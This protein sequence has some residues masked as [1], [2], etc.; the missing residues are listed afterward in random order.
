MEIN[1]LIDLIEQ[2]IKKNFEVNK[3]NIKDESFLHKKHKNFNKKKFY[4]KLTVD[5]SELKKSSLL[6]SNRKIYKVL[7]DEIKEHIH[8][9]QIVIN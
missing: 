4:I 7:E 3:I 2:K 8:S 1:K 6:E 5:S 9:I